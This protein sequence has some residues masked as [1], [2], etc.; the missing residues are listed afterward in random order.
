MGRGRDGGSTDTAIILTSRVG[1]RRRRVF[2]YIGSRIGFPA[3]TGTH[4]ILS[5]PGV[6][7][8]KFFLLFSLAYCFFFASSLF[9]ISSPPYF[10]T[11]VMLRPCSIYL[12]SFL[13][14]YMCVCFPSAPSSYFNSDSFFWSPTIK[15]ASFRIIFCFVS[16]TI[17]TTAAVVVFL[18]LFSGLL[19]YVILQRCQRRTSYSD[20]KNVRCQR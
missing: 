16:P 18:F 11:F 17:N 15:Y 14:T 20:P 10:L 19:V 7:S 1:R 13:S 5:P 2:G 4:F 3:H 12:R 8:S 6:R 9:S